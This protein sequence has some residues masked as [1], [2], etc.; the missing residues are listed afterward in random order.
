MPSRCRSSC[1]CCLCVVRQ[2]HLDAVLHSAVQWSLAQGLVC[3]RQQRSRQQLYR[4]PRCCWRP[5]HP[6]TQ[7]HVRRPRLAR[8]PPAAPRCNRQHSDPWPLA[9]SR[10]H[11]CHSHHRHGLRQHQPVTHTI[12]INVHIESVYPCHCATLQH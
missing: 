2:G 8:P 6:P 5:R 4:C 3:L 10:H 12:K 7:P 1:V 9:Y 11:R